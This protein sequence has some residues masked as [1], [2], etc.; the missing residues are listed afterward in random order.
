[1]LS[2]LASTPEYALQQDAYEPLQEFAEC[3]LAWCHQN[4]PEE[5]DHLSDAETFFHRVTR[6]PEFKQC[7]LRVTNVR[8]TYY[9]VGI[10]RV[11]DD[12]ESN[13]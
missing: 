10:V 1:M 8:D 9:L 12:S 4:Y 11:H 3:F 2:F 7:G 6:T 5:R 13:E